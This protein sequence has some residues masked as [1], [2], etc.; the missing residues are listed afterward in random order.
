MIEK[1]REIMGLLSG[2]KQQYDGAKQALEA[3]Q[4]LIEE[5]E[6]V[7]DQILAVLRHWHESDEQAK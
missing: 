7:T 6:G 1:L 2:Y 3:A 5:A 4:R